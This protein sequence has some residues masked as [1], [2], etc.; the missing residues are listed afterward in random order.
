[1]TKEKIYVYIAWSDDCN[2]GDCMCMHE[3]I[4]GIYFDEITA[5]EIARNLYHGRVEKHEIL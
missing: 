2:E 5:R 1:M 3:S 4:H